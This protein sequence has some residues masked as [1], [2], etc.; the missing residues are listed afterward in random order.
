MIQGAQAELPLWICVCAR[1]TLPVIPPKSHSLLKIFFTQPF[2]VA[3]IS[4]KRFFFLFL[5]LG[6]LET[7]SKD[8]GLHAAEKPKCQYGSLSF[9]LFLAVLT[10][11]SLSFYKITELF[12]L[13]K[14]FKIIESL[15]QVCPVLVDLPPEA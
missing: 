9:N 4:N 5:L 10:C 8:L 6:L 3:D 7:L 12:G 13:G 2:C 15:S 1:L 11:F 14:T